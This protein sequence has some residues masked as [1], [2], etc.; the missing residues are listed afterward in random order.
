MGCFDTTLPCGCVGNHGKEKIA[1]FPPSRE[2][3]EDE[4]AERADEEKKA[5][6]A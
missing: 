3:A 6:D 4:D 1:S 2:A 5:W